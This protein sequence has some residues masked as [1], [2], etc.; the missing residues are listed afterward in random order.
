MKFLRE[1]TYFVAV[2]AAIPKIE[3]LD[4]LK[5]ELQF[6]IIDSISPV[7]KTAEGRSGAIL[8]ILNWEEQ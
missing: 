4:L 2:G 5:N 8:P 1:G 7:A 3:V 6:M